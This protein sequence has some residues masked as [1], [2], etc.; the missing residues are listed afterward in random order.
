MCSGRVGSSYSNSG[1]CRVTVFYK[2]YE[3]HVILKSC[4]TPVY[5]NNYLTCNASERKDESNI[6]FYAEITEDNTTRN[7]KHENM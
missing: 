1:T 4:W 6:V 3:H 2:R 7:L 5:I